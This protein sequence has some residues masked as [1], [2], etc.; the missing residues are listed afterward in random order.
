MKTTT[1]FAHPVLTLILALS[2]LLLQHSLALVHVL[3]ALLIGGLLPRL[4]SGFLPPA[5]PVRWRPAAALLLKVLWD[6]IQ[7]N[8]TVARQVLG[9][10]DALQPAWV[11]VPLAL[12]HPTAISLLAAIITTTPGTVSCHIDEGRREILVHAL[13][14]TD[15]VQMALDIKAQ[16]EALLLAIFESQPERL[17]APS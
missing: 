16:Y 12:T 7:S 10:M 6:I 9:P 14:C 3:S 2:W 8:I 4:L 5:T 15:P 1:W 17:G 13:N 11:P